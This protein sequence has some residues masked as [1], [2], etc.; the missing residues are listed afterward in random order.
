[1]G[2]KSIIWTGVANKFR[3]S[4]VLIV[5]A[6]V[7]VG[8]KVLVFDH[9]RAS[10][11]VLFEDVSPFSRIS[12]KGMTFGASWGD[13]NGDGLPDLYLPNHGNPGML[14]QNV[15]AG[16]FRNVTDSFFT[17]EQL[18]GDEHGAAWADYDNDGDQDFVVL[19]GGGRGVGQAPNRFYLNT[20][21]QFEEIAALNGASNPYARA[22]MPLW[23]DFDHDGKLD[24]FLGAVGR[25]DG[26]APGAIFLQTND[27]QFQEATELAPFANA[28]VPFCLS[29]ELNNEQGEELVC[30]VKGA[31]NRTG[32][33]LNT[34]N[35]PLEELD[36]LPVSHF[37]DATIADFNGD[38]R[39]D[40]FLA[41]R[42]PEDAL[43]LGQ[44]GSNSIFTNFQVKPNTV[45]DDLGF[46]FRSKGLVS[47]KVAP[48][49]PADSLA[50]NQIFL[51]SAGLHPAQLAFKLSR[52]T[53]GVAG[54]ALF[55]PGEQVGM[56]IGFT[57]QDLWQVSFSTSAEF[58]A[59]SREKNHQIALLI[60]STQEITD[61]AVIEGVK[62]TS[63][64][65]DRLLVNYPGE[66]K[67]EGRKRGINSS[68]SASQNVVAGD[69]DNDMDVDLYLVA[70]GPV[71]NEP[72]ILYLNDGEGRFEPVHRAGGA[73]GADSGIGDAV[74]MADYDGDGF[75]DLLVANGG[76]MGRSY[77]LAAEEG[78]YRLYHNIGN[79]N[80]WLE[81]DLEGTA[82]NRDGIGAMVYVTAGDKVQMRLQDGG[83]HNRAQN[84][85][86]LH[87]GLAKHD[88]VDEI[89]VVW[90]SGTVQVLEKVAANQ[91]IEIREKA[92]IG[93]K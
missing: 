64:S 34:A 67:K 28:S 51:G 62:Q 14:Y 47:F 23:N 93:E 41:R 70:S 15:G 39:M 31:K 80:N 30:R 60:S 61:A 92:E 20:G 57:A 40:V 8:L 48:E 45:G 90:P 89:K 27:G 38:G 58:I 54:L 2:A 53:A 18:V 7:A 49:Y 32:H 56:Y 3:W 84:H 88:Q 59:E 52:E 46:S 21:D 43:L 16:R 85:K 10:E 81:I 63:Q 9:Y 86:R 44:R 50:P 22:R 87:F 76:S 35:A 4:V 55:Q 11:P 37:E 6:V 78:G 42:T 24:L 71:A 75:L 91:I 26:R 83:Y 73:S 77:G 25:D 69:F 13:F 19:H 1:M 66:L 12:Y 79:G 29:G 33:V 36:L 5:A 17:V 68:L 72:N 74:A 65:E 82:S